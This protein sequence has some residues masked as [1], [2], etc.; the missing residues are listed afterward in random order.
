ML[1]KA[2]AFFYAKALL[3]KL[4]ED[5]NLNAQ[6]LELTYNRLVEQYGKELADTAFNNAVVSI[7]IY[8]KRKGI[9]DEQLESISI[10]TRDESNSRGNKE[11]TSSKANN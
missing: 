7:I 10:S 11:A 6:T 1:E 4:L 8:L 3:H 5:N 9:S 2:K